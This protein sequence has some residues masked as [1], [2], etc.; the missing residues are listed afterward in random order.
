[1]V[2]SMRTI[3]LVSLL[4][5]LAVGGYLVSAQWRSAGPTSE[6][7]STAAAVAG[8]EVGTL[9]LQQAALALEQHRAA[10][11]G[12]AGA[13]LGGFGVVLRSAD[14]SSYCVATVRAPVFHLAGPGGAPTAGG[15]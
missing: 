3:S 15:C 6:T 12:Y 14:S 8:G 1:M 5:A 4:T 13:E 2:P 9:N 10:T 11:G 7:A